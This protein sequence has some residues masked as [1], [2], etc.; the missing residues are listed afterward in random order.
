[1]FAFLFI[2]TWGICIIF[3]LVHGVYLGCIACLA[4]DGLSITFSGIKNNHADRQAANLRCLSP[5]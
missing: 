5:A 4:T 2:S 3:F 1:V